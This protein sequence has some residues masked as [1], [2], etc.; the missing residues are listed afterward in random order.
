MGVRVID[1]RPPK[2]AVVV[3]TIQRRIED[4]IYPPGSAI[5]SEATLIAEF[6]V[7]RPTAVRALGIL[8]QDGWIDAEQGKGRFVR[9][10]SAIA[11]RR[12]A[13]E[14]TSLINQEESAEVTIVRAG[15]VLASE[16]VAGALD[17]TEGTPVIERQRLVASDLGPVELGGFYLPV[18][19]A[20][21]T[22]IGDEKPI[23]EGVL[24]RIARRKGIEFDHAIERIGA[25]HASKEE[26]KLLAVDSKECLLSV[27][28][29]IFDR[30]GVPL[31]AVDLLLPSS[32][33][34]LEDTFPLVI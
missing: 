8:Q 33:H 28:L 26:A 11:S 12:P 15:P 16:R 10:R 27:L 18:D 14:M 7:S 31:M 22:G 3:N 2:Y 4:G 21:G 32:R 20:S 25:R 9:S 34:E 29:T 19:L 6:G 17:L 13:H 30:A 24:S 5:P 1:I 23:L